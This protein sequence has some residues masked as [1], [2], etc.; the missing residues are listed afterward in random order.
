MCKSS[1]AI[2][3]A[4]ATLSAPAAA[5]D[6]TW[7]V[8]A[9][10]GAAYG[11]NLD[12]AVLPGSTGLGL[13]PG[14]RA[15]TLDPASGFDA[16]AIFGHDFGSFRL[17]AEGSYR[18][19]SA[20]A[21]V[22]ATATPANPYYPR[23]AASGRTRT[24]SFMVNALFDLGPDDGPQLFA[25]G[26][27][28]YSHAQIDAR[29]QP[30]ASTAFAIN[31]A[32]DGFAWQ[33]LAGARYPLTDRIDIGV[34]YRYFDQGALDIPASYTATGTGAAAGSDTVRTRVRSH[35]ALL[36]LSYS[37]LPPPP[38][39]AEAIEVT[40]PEPDAAPPAEPQTPLP[41]PCSKGR[42]IVFFDW[43]KAEIS[44]EAAAVLDSAVA[45]YGN[46]ARVPVMLAGHTDRSGSGAYN[47]TLSERRSRSVTQYLIA[48]GVADSAISSQG[49][50]EA[51]GRV[52]TA[53]GVRE[54]QN[55]RVEITLG[56]GSG[57]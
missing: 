47:Q 52:Q 48:H 17:E 20:R 40:P 53:D 36:T 50:G 54:L 11:R 41:P 45:A 7:Y 25:G 18:R 2:A 24:L 29:A 3:V 10:V 14:T 44:A 9:D 30:A 51:N 32:D 28:G 15:A 6:D 16:G 13:T 34:K 42:Y 5:H 31:G 1:L 35:S 27:A 8:E 46:C 38:P 26:G 43:D 12:F 55:R 22:V 56:P 39:P 21:M 23:A 37:F 19:Q 49:F 57:T 4:A 33:A